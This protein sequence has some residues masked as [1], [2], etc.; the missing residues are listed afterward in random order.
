MRQRGQIKLDGGCQATG[1]K[2]NV[3]ADWVRVMGTLTITFSSVKT[4]TIQVDEVGPESSP[5]EVSLEACHYLRCPTGKP[6]S[7]WRCVE[8]G[9]TY[10]APWEAAGWQNQGDQP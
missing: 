8:L 7:W 2:A 3:K 9:G 1:D 6:E 5:L 10:S 4:L